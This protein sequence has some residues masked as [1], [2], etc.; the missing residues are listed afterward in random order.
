LKI[1]QLGKYYPPAT[2]GIEAHTQTL[3]QSLAARGHDVTVVVVNHRDTTGQDVTFDATARTETVEEMDGAVRV[4][5]IGRRANVA[6]LDITPGL[7]RM[8]GRLRRS[9]PDIWHL[10]T[11]NITMMLAMASMPGLKPLVITHHSDIV[12]QKVL[13]YAVRPL[14]RLIYRRAR[15]VLP[16]SAAYAAGSAMLKSLGHIVMPLPLGIDLEPYCNPSS[17]AVAYSK[18]LRAAH[19]DVLWLAVGRLIY[20]K[21]L[22]IGFEA[23]RDVPGKLIII[24]G[25]PHE[26]EWRQACERFGVADR[27]VWLGR[28]SADEK[29]GAY[30]AATAYWFP[31]NARAEGFGLVQVEAMAAGCPVIN[32]AIEH[33]GVPWVSRDGDSGLTVPVNDAA[34]FAAA[35]NRLL[36]EPGLR[37]RLAAGARQRAIG[38]F[39]QTI[40]AERCEAIY[41]EILPSHGKLIP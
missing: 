41:R 25:G 30:L 14:E 19:G 2:G 32:T 9:E 15:A 26:T 8:I 18:T 20:Y 24:G 35:A 17:E 1:I 21:A 33:S 7:S 3:C 39:D 40:M 6:K 12:R 27:V 4:L 29:V 23:L 10:H 37:N 31:S 34:A 22:Q 16:T 28:A 5:R 13:K 36:N 38:E 11:P